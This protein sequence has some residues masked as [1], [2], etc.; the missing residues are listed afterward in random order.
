MKYSRFDELRGLYEVFEDDRLHALNADLPTP[1]LGAEVNG[2]GVP[3][4]SAGRQ[5]PAGAKLIG[6]SWHPVGVMVTGGQAGFGGVSE[7]LERYTKKDLLIVAGT[8]AGV[9]GLSLIARAQCPFTKGLLGGAVAL[10]ALG[11]S[12]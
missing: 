3:A 2:I 9:Y 12:K 6:T 11:A 4:R 1:Q 7:V 8:V 10:I 5:L